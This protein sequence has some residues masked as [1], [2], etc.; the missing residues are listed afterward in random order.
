MSCKQINNKKKK[1][2]NLNIQHLGGVCKV[3][4]PDGVKIFRKN[5]QSK[6]SPAENGHGCHTRFQCRCHGKLG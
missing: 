4:R 5:I 6:V 2:Q 1:P 3:C